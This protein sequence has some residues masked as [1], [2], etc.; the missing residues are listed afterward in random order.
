MQYYVEL[1]EIEYK[2][3]D[4]KL[5]LIG[6]RNEVK[7]RQSRNDT[8]KLISIERKYEKTVKNKIIPRIRLKEICKELKMREYSTE[9]NKPT[10]RPKIK[11][12]FG[13]YNANRIVKISLD[14]S[15]SSKT[16]SNRNKSHFGLT[17]KLFNNSSK[18]SKHNKQF[19]YCSNKKKDINK[20]LTERAKRL[21]CS[22][23]TQT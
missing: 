13:E 21:T 6:I 4:P 17:V 18:L 16:N 9:R 3:P 20:L 11:S 10:E 14:R 15:K 22:L 1:S 7:S 5:Y 23:S 2:F 8:R 12:T 19:V